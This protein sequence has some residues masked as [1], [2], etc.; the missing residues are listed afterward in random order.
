MVQHIGRRLTLKQTAN[1]TFI[2]GGGW[3][4]RPEA[5]P[6]R[7]SV[8][9]PSAAGNAAIALRVMP[10]LSDVRVII[11]GPAYARPLTISTPLSGSLATAPACC[12]H[13]SHGVHAGTHC[14]PHAGR[15][16]GHIV[17]RALEPEPASGVYT[18]PYGRFDQ[19]S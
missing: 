10:A 3:P 13:R 7:Y 11:C 18:G 1:G 6:E 9:W 16:D 15:V 8:R 4:A 14:H 2:I 5:T 19:R 17:G 12:V